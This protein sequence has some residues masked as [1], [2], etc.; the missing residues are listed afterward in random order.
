[1]D[2]YTEATILAG[3]RAAR[4]S[5][6]LIVVSHRGGDTAADQRLLVQ[7]GLVRCLTGEALAS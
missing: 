3:I 2:A 4:P 6:T 5:M 7:D 1:M